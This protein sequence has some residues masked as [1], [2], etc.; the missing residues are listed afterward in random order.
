MVLLHLSICSSCLFT[1]LSLSLSLR[2]R[3]A[4]SP[5][6][7]GTAAGTGTGTG[8]PGSGG[9]GVAH[10]DMGKR[11]KRGAHAHTHTHTHT[12]TYTNSNVKTE[13]QNGS[14]PLI[15]QV[16]SSLNA[17]TGRFPGSGSGRQVTDLELTHATHRVKVWPFDAPVW[18]I[19]AGT[20][21]ATWRGCTGERVE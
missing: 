8:H 4:S 3:P 7:A 17:L 20:G 12:H 13:M 21:S 9:A 14:I 2:R 10:L 1:S 16:G 5:C 15:G 18:R 6:T 19:N 11:R